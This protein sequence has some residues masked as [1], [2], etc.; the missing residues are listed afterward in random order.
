MEFQHG[1]GA[2]WRLSAGGYSGEWSSIANDGQKR[3][4]EYQ[5]ALKLPD[6]R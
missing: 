2:S 3:G 4:F 6:R 5:V 1:G